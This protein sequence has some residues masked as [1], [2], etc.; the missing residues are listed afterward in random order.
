MTADP[1][2]FAKFLKYDFDMEDDYYGLHE[3]HLA[4]L[5]SKAVEKPIAANR[6]EHWV[7]DFVDGVAN[8]VEK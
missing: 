4:K 2:M 3:W 1:A 7:F 5:L 6:K 8:V